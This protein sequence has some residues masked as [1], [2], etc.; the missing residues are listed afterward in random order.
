MKLQK[1]LAA[2]ARLVPWVKRVDWVGRGEDIATVAKAVWRAGKWV[3]L[4]V[5]TVGTWIVSSA[6]AALIVFVG[7]GLVLVLFGPLITDEW[8]QRRI[9][10]AREQKLLEAK[11]KAEERRLDGWGDILPE[12]ERLAERLQAERLDRTGEDTVLLN[13]N[14]LKLAGIA[15]RL[16]ERE[17]PRPDLWPQ[18]GETREWETFLWG[19]VQRVNASEATTLPTL[20][21]DVREALEQHREAWDPDNLLRRH[22]EEQEPE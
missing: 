18:H 12:M 1:P 4:T 14:R 9:A 13:R 2:L 20:H 7:V 8:I 5:A 10:R 22:Q 19:F 11:G 17:I 3:T 21:Q 6:G 15:K 16:D